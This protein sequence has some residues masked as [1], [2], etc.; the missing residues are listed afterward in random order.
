[1]LWSGKG[2]KQ[3]NLEGGGMVPGHIGTPYGKCIR[4]LDSRQEGV[5]L[6]VASSNRPWGAG[7]V[8]MRPGR[9]A[10]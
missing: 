6:A 1:M 3:A 10:P 2:A 8:R 4:R 7:S 9:A 5:M